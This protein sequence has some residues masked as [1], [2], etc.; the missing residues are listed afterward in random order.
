MKSH[1]VLFSIAILFG[2]SLSAEPV[3]F[4]DRVEKSF[5]A[6]PGGLLTFHSNVANAEIVTGNTDTVRVD[7]ERTAKVASQAQADELLRQLSLEMVQENGGV[8]IVALV[9]EEPNRRGD[10]KLHLNARITIPRRFNVDL[11]TVGSST[12]ADVDG[13]A[14]LSTSG[15]SLKVGNVSGPV[16]AKAG[17]G[18]VIVGDVGGNLEVRSGGGSIKAG[19][20]KGSVIARAGGGSVM[21]EEAT[22]TIDATAEGGSVSAYLS[23]Q[24]RGDSQLT[25]NA[26]SIDLR[27]PASVAVGVDA[28]CTAGRVTSDFA[29]SLQGDA[30]STRLKGDI[31]GGG[32]SLRLRAT[33]GNIHLRKADN[34]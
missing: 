10:R 8:K 18:S 17:G 33:A 34:K 9:P 5:Q 30:A 28:T 27:L 22:E 14:N 16:V 29:V 13:T 21:I 25:A 6:K 24:P 23:Q 3:G 26:G 4:T 1:L 31:G 19:R 11:R 7:I 15:G 12:V 20:V 32:P 2:A